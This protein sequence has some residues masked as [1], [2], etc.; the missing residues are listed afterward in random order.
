MNI[1]KNTEA[2]VQSILVDHKWMPAIEITVKTEM[3]RISHQLTGRVKELIE[4]YETP[5]P[6]LELA[7]NEMEA[8]VNAHLRNMGFQW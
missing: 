3:D 6:Q 1:S 4:R 8:K 2:D 7:L 5:L